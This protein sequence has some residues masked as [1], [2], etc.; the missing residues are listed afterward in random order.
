MLGLYDLIFIIAYTILL[1]VVLAAW[2]KARISFT[3]IVKSLVIAIVARIVIIIVILVLGIFTIPISTVA[4]SYL[5]GAWI[6]ILLARSF[7]EERLGGVKLSNFIM[8]SIILAIII[9]DVLVYLLSM[10]G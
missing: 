2:Y 7:W 4:I 9:V 1:L 6:S 5:C 10:I 3:D 8:T